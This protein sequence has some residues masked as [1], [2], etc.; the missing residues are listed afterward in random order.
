MKQQW[1]NV[2]GRIMAPKNVHVLLPRMFECV[3]LPGK[4]DF[5]DVITDLEI[6]RLT[7]IIQ[8]NPV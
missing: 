2:L 1:E 7:W 8:G 4:R 3:I 5:A 6:Q